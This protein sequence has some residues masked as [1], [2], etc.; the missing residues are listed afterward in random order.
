MFNKRFIRK[1]NQFRKQNWSAPAIMSVLILVGMIIIFS[2]ETIGLTNKE[3]N[4]ELRSNAP[5]KSKKIFF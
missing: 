5:E 3:K 4:L 2:F 1:A